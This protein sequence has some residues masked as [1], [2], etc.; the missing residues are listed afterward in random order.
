MT[1]ESSNSSIPPIGH[2]ETGSV[3]RRAVAVGAAW[4]TPTVALVISAPLAAASTPAEAGVHVIPGSVVQGVQN[5]FVG[6]TLI[7]VR[8][9][10]GRGVAGNPVR[11]SVLAGEVEFW[12]NYTRTSARKTLDLVTDAAGYAYIAT[13]HA[14]DFTGVVTL[15]IDAGPGYGSTTTTQTII[16][17]RLVEHFGI[18]L[19][20]KYEFPAGPH[21][22][23]FTNLV[24]SNTEGNTNSSGGSNRY[25]DNNFGFTYYSI[26]L[27]YSQKK[28]GTG[29][30]FS[31]TGGG[32]LMFSTGL[33][34]A[35]FPITHNSG[36]PNT[37]PSYGSIQLPA[38]SIIYN[39]GYRWPAGSISKIST[40][41][42][43]LTTFL[44]SGEAL[45]VAIY[46]TMR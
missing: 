32:P 10:S 34:S 38:K 17:S 12:P 30:D 16:P 42:T 27:P 13:E 28:I 29:V 14:T 43:Y 19:Y 22:P 31:L 26:G 25:P 5:G 4:T 40:A 45:P 3:T 35:T 24:V 21:Q 44:P 1:M 6:G 7:Q 18:L 20:S 33:F 46:T 23:A 11:V 39:P 15:R 37:F 36:T 8:D 41:G 2:R 9:E